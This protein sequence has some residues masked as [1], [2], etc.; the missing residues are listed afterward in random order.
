MEAIP[1]IQVFRCA[2]QTN[3]NFTM[4]LALPL[5]LLIILYSPHLH[6]SLLAIAIPW[7]ASVENQNSPATN[8]LSAYF[9]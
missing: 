7:V 6:K 3:G 4:A 8:T 1:A 2:H 9:A 5:L